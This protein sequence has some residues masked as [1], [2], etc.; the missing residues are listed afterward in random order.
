MVKT[1]EKSIGPYFWG[2]TRGRYIYFKK[3]VSPLPK[4]AGFAKNKRHH[5]VEKPMEPKKSAFEFT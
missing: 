3:R 2:G 1:V 4:P 5:V